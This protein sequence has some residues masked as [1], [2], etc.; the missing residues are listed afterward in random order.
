MAPFPNQMPL[1][2][3]LKLSCAA[4]QFALWNQQKNY[5]NLYN[6]VTTLTPPH[7]HKHYSQPYSSPFPCPSPTSA[8][9]CPFEH[10]QN[11]APYLASV[12]VFSRNFRGTHFMWKWAGGGRWAWCG[13][14]LKKLHAALPLTPLVLLLLLLLLLVLPMQSHWC[15]HKKATT[16]ALNCRWAGSSE[17]R[18]SVA[19]VFCGQQTSK[20][21]NC[22]D[23][24]QKTAQ[25]CRLKAIWI[26][27]KLKLPPVA[28][29]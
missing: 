28:A 17:R 11:F 9:A 5:N 27:I 26:G 19:V 14:P 21:L 4:K 13:K 29:K 20:W 16:I 18:G 2:T 24:F 6:T 7:P 8:A 10:I 23:C 15:W 3:F 22:C 25:C 12:L 1:E